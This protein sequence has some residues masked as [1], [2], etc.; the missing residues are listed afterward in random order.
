MKFKGKPKMHV[1]DHAQNKVIGVFDSKGILNIEDE[2][3][4]KKMSKKF[5]AA[6]PKKEKR[7]LRKI[8]SKRRRKNDS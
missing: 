7:Q 2:I 6:I 4:I 8:K 5:E 1:I 3:N